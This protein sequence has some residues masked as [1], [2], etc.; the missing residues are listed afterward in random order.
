MSIPLWGNLEKS[1]DDKNTI[2]EAIASAI[3][4]HEADPTAHLGDNE[5]LQNHKHNEIIDHPAGSVVIDK[6]SYNQFE[7]NLLWSDFQ[8]WK[9][10]LPQTSGNQV[11]YNSNSG[12]VNYYLSAASVHR[13]FK[14]SLDSSGFVLDGS[15]SFRLDIRMSQE[16][17]YLTTS[18]NLF[19]FGFE[20]DISSFSGICFKIQ[21]GKLYT[22]Y[23]NSLDVMVWNEVVGFDYM[24]YIQMSVIGL[25]S[26]MYDKNT[27]LMQWLFNGQVVYQVESFFTNGNVGIDLNFIFSG[28]LASISSYIQADLISYRLLIDLS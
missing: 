2:D 6:L 18:Y 11:L 24:S 26:I 23:K 22:G 20:S 14:K 1:Q 7:Y 15:C 4:A 25:Y 10:N 21:N 27:D 17:D 12:V 9:H 8:T 19:G 28:K 3:A 16:S 13:Y 5:S